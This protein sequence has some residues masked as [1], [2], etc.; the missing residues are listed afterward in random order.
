MPGKSGKILVLVADCRQQ[1]DNVLDA[2]HRVTIQGNAGK[3]PDFLELLIGQ[4]LF[5]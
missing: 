5:A 1:S 4:R 3:S 2:L